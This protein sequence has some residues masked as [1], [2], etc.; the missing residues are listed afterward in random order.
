MRIKIKEVKSFFKS[1]LGESSLRKFC[2][3]NKLN[4]STMKNYYQGKHSLP[5]ELFDFLVSLSNDGSY[6]E[7]KKICLKDSWGFIKAGKISAS[8]QDNKKR[9]QHAR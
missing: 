9:M 4:Y 8:L 1:I 2:E 5:R 6:W 7:R 3:L